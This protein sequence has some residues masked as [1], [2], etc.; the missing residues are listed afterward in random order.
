MKIFVTGGTGF[1]GQALIRTLIDH[2]HEVV[3]LARE[4]SKLNR[5]LK[6]GPTSIKGD[7][8]DPDLLYQGMKECRQVYHVAALAR[9]WV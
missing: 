6:N 2:G 9:S 3:A 1:I 7:L 4:P 5:I 8:S